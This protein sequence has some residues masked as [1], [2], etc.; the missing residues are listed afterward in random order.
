MPRTI[1]NRQGLP[2]SLYN[3]L[4][5]DTYVGGG[6][7]SITRLIA[8]PRMVALRKRHENEIVEDATD[9]IWSLLGQ[10]A[11]VVAERAAG[12]DVIVET[13]LSKRIAGIPKPD[14]TLWE[15]DVSGQPDVYEKKDQ[16]VSDYKITSV[17]SFMFGDK[18]EWDQQVNLQAML[19]RH[20]G[21]EVKGVRIIAILRDW[22]K[23]KAQYEKD[24]PAMAAHVVNFPLWT[25]EQQIEFAEDRVKLHQK[26][27]KEFKLSGYNGDVLP[28]CTE[29][30]RWFRGAKFV[31]KRKQIKKDTINKKADRLADTKEEAEK[32]IREN[33]AP[34][35]TEYM[36]VEERPG[37]NIRCLNYCDVWSFCPF[38][39]ALHAAQ[40]LVNQKSDDD[41]ATLPLG[42]A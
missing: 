35:N 18:P 11:H 32:Y 15:W 12:N 23:R 4:S 1:T 25:L 19:H 34:K 27:Q 20:K 24:Y 5:R 3:A 40:P 17:W 21:D 26:A 13:R 41:E 8:P 30:E 33:P 31:V 6:D 10:A 38:G 28:L 36:P 2:S 7:I 22:Q 42:V 16:I 29:K 37:E 14:S 39:K 9:R